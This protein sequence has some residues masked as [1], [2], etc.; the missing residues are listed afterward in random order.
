MN[1]YVY[2]NYEYFKQL[3]FLNAKT[4]DMYSNYCYREFIYPQ[5]IL[6]SHLHEL[7]FFKWFFFVAGIGWY[8][9]ASKALNFWRGI[10]AISVA[11]DSYRGHCSEHLIENLSL[12]DKNWAC[13]MYLNVYVYSKFYSW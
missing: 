8:S 4:S 10:F 9:K 5:V 13:G 7:I 3:N 11:I 6:C 1:A 12:Y 2:Y